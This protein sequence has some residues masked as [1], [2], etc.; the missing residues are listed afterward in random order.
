MILKITSSLHRPQTKKV[1]HD[2]PVFVMGKARPLL[3]LL[4]LLLLLHNMLEGV[5]GCVCG[6]G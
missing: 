5:G 3:L 4:L 6:G 2:G 1:V